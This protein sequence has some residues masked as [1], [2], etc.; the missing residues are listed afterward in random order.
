MKT[1][2]RSSWF[3]CH[4]ARAD[5]VSVVPV[6]NIYHDVSRQTEKKELNIDIIASSAKTPDL[7]VLLSYKCQNQKEKPSTIASCVGLTA[8]VIDLRTMLTNWRIQSAHVVSIIRGK[9]NVSTRAK[10][11]SGVNCARLTK[12]SPC[13]PIIAIFD[14]LLEHRRRILTTFKRLAVNSSDIL[15]Y[16]ISWT[17]TDE[18]RQ[19]YPTLFTWAS[20][21]SWLR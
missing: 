20:L 2:G 18:K 1:A 16:T 7:R 4:L 6:K 12:L 13:S 8:S 14:I 10:N 11:G 17:F 21:M 5:I 9:Q 3:Y 19:L 15:K